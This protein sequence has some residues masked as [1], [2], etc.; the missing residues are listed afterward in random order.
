MKLDYF[1]IKNKTDKSSLTHGY[2]MHYEDAIE[3]YLK[4]NNIDSFLILEIGVYAG[5]SLNMWSDYLKSLRI[6]HTIVGI[7]LDPSA[8]T[9]QNMNRNIF[10]EIGD[11]T[12]LLFLRKIIDKYGHFDVIIDDGSHVCMHQQMS[13][14][15]LFDFVKNG[16]IYIV[17]DACTSYWAQYN[18]NGT[19]SMIE[20]CKSLIDDVNFHGI[21]PEGKVD[22][23]ESRLIDY[24][25]AN[26]LKINTSIMSIHFCN[27]TILIHKNY[28]GHPLISRLMSSE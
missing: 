15:F 8:M 5:A 1:A 24:I 10:V 25:E 7:D 11:Q 26:N 6:K 2:C 14:S 28:S 16:G 9:S 21:A 4:K 20:Y 27:S 23:E 22:R 19:I 13:F 3:L 18:N 12:D 17:E